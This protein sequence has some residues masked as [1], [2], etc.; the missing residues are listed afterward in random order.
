[1]VG[2]QGRHR[3]RPASDPQGEGAPVVFEIGTTLREARVRRKLTL[4][5]VEE[6]TKIRVKYVQAME[7]EDFDL[8]PG[9]AYV[10]GFLQTYAT[11]LGLDSSI[12]LDEYRSRG[13]HREEHQPFG[14]SSVIGKPR[15]HR[16]RNTLVF[17][18][19]ACL[20]VLAVIYVLGLNAED[21]TKTGGTGIDPGLLSPS[22]S[23]TPSSSATPSPSPSPGVGPN[24][25]ML[26][27]SGGP[28]WLEVRSGGADGTV[29]Y[30]G[31][32]AAGARQLFRQTP[33]W[34]KI[35]NPPALAISVGGK[36]MPRLEGVGP[37]IVTIDDG[38]VLQD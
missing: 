18:A 30:S 10:K 16:G 37:L 38:K 5:Q 17:I 36:D 11:Y 31:T 14:G 34:L 9:Q 19:V 15:S 13:V 28:C 29:L 23:A 27:A 33:L 12:I 21:A 22:P 8:M 6:D 26:A 2:H 24:V 7:N 35:G 1:M 20:L 4:Q 25:V 3:P 32:V